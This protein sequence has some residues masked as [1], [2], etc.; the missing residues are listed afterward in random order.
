MY[1]ELGSRPRVDLTVPGDWRWI[2]G[3]RKTQAGFKNWAAAT[4][5]QLYHKMGTKSM[6]VE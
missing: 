6:Y 2:W 1:G 3:L 5:Y 4:L